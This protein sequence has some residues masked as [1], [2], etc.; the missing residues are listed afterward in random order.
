MDLQLLTG[1]NDYPDLLLAKDMPKVA[2]NLTPEVI[3]DGTRAI[4]L[5][6]VGTESGERHYVCSPQMSPRDIVACN[7]RYRS[8]LRA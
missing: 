3:E 8:N 2:T 7:G 4:D 6:D 5:E 1:I